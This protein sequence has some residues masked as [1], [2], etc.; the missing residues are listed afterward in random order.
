M[1]TEI[2]TATVARM[3]T[4]QDFPSQ[5]AVFTGRIHLCTLFSGD[6]PAGRD[7]PFYQFQDEEADHCFWVEDLE[8]REGRPMHLTDKDMADEFG[9]A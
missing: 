3:Y 9:L 7:V 5:D 6:H 8:G 2:I 4:E 1:S